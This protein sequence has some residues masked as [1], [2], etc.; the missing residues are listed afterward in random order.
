ME[1]RA[2]A[3]PSRLRELSYFYG[4]GKKPLLSFDSGGFLRSERPLKL[5]I[6]I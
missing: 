6:L 1:G 4:N 3:F 5:F 2:E